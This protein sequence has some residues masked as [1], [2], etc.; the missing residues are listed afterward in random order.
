MTASNSNKPDSVPR[1]E[2]EDFLHAFTHELRN[3]LN[4]ISL[5]AADLGEQAAARIDTLRI[6]QQALECS[7][8]LKRVREALA[9][10]DPQAEKAALSEVAKKLREKSI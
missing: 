9:P 6:Q 8:F 3:R 2:F 7:A 1:E 10:E 5:E 4:A